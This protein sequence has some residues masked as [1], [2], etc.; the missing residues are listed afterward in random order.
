[1][2]RPDVGVLPYLDVLT[3]P[4]WQCFSSISDLRSFRNMPPVE[5]SAYRDEF[6]DVGMH[7]HFAL[8]LQGFAIA[9]RDSVPILP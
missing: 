5:P 4:I 6:V 9:L 2:R 1:M 3:C 8:V 7:Q